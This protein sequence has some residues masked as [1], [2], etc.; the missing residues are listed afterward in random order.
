MSDDRTCSHSLA[1]YQICLYEA[2]QS[3]LPRVSE[4]GPTLAH[5][6]KCAS[7]GI[8]QSQQYWA[9]P[10]GFAALTPPGSDRNEIER[11]AH[12]LEIVC[13]VIVSKIPADERRS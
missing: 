4:Y 7:L 6:L 2:Y 8:V 11:V 13:N 9:P 12:S 10:T 1:S 3:V 5:S